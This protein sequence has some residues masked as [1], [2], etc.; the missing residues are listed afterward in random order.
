MSSSAVLLIAIRICFQ[1]LTLFGLTN[2]RIQAMDKNTRSGIMVLITQE[3]KKMDLNS[4]GCEF[5]VGTNFNF[6]MDCYSALAAEFD[7]QATEVA[8]DFIGYNTKLRIMFRL[9]NG[10]HHADLGGRLLY[11]LLVPM[12]PTTE[13]HGAN[14]IRT[15]AI[16]RYYNPDVHKAIMQ[17][18]YDPAFVNW[19]T[20]PNRV[21][22]LITDKTVTALEWTKYPRLVINGMHVFC[23]MGHIDR[24]VL[25]DMTGPV[26]HVGLLRCHRV[27]KTEIH[28]NPLAK[29]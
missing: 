18:H 17:R 27:T 28:L 13:V 24:V 8:V 6:N 23:A 10:I 11:L 16:G 12:F 21:G 19:P 25:M 7:T 14:I 20:L 9:R 5:L 15:W 26:L 29:L 1:I 22:D 2:L 3:S 4:Y